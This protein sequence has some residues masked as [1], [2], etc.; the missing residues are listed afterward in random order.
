MLTPLNR[1]LHCKSIA[2]SAERLERFFGS[3]MILR[4]RRM[5]RGTKPQQ[6]LC[7]EVLVC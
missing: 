1:V 4:G 5:H 7:L 2:V 6:D 3:L